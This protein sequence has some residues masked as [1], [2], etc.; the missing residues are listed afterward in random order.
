MAYHY[1]V[2]YCAYVY[3]CMCTAAAVY[4]S[5]SAIC[6]ALHA[7]RGVKDCYAHAHGVTLLYSILHTETPNSCVVNEATLTGESI[8]QMKEGLLRLVKLSLYWLYVTYYISILGYL[9]AR[10][11]ARLQSLLWGHN[12]C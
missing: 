4:T 11:V 2:Q 8:P 7:S 12:Y 10:I 1:G 6:V 5:T 3:V 9:S